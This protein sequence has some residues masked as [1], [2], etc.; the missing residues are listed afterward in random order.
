L[1]TASGTL[2]GS[3][4]GAMAGLYLGVIAGDGVE[5]M[6]I[7]AAVGGVAGM[8]LGA[9]EYLDDQSNTVEHCLRSRGYFI[10][11]A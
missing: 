5:G 11:P 4:K 3:F 7:G 6:I 8:G 10:N 2:A 9:K 1:K